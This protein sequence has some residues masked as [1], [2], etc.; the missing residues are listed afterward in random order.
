[1]AR[2]L[3]QPRVCRWRDC[4][5]KPAWGKFDDNT[6]G[7]HRL[8]HHSADVAACFEALLGDPVL[9]D[10]FA[11]AA[12][13]PGFSRLTGARLTYLAYLHDLGK[14]NVGF[15]FNVLKDCPGA[16]RKASHLEAA[17]WACRRPD[18]FEELNIRDLVSWGAG[19]VDELIRAALA[20]HGRPTRDPD[21]CK[22]RDDI[23]RP[24][25]D[26]DPLAAA[27]LLVRRGR[28]WFPEAFEDGPAI[29]S[30]PTLTHLFAGLLAVA[31]Q[32]GSNEDFFPHE[33]DPDPQYAD[34]ARRLARGALRTSGFRREGWA[35]EAH[36]ADFRTS[37]DYRSIFDFDSPRPLQEEMVRASLDSPLL[38]LEGETGSGKTE[39]ALIRFARLWR[40]GKVDGLYFAL[41]TRAAAVQIHERV[42]RALR[43][44]FPSRAE[45]GTVLAIPG[46]L[47]IGETHGQRVGRFEVEWR[48]APDEAGLQARWAAESARKFLSATA[49]VGTVDQAML[50]ALQ[51]KWAHFRCTS[52]ARSLLVVDEIH[53]SDVYMTE[54]LRGVL[55]DHLAVG[56]HALLMSA[57]LGA[58]ARRR[59]VRNAALRCGVPDVAK[60]KSTPYP[61]L[62]LAGRDGFRSIRK[63][64]D[65]GY[66]RRVRMAEDPIMASPPRIAAHVLREARRGGRV[67]VILNT[68]GQAQEVFRE[69]LGQGG[70]ARCLQLGGGPALHHSRFAAEDRRC[71]DRAVERALGK[72]RE[73]GGRIVIGT[74]TL[75]QSLDIDADVLI[76]HLCPVDVLLQRIGRLHR[77]PETER[78]EGFAEARCFVLVPEGGL[79][80]G[81]TGGLLRYGLGMSRNGGIYRDLRVLEMTRRLV[82][83]RAIWRIP[84]DNRNLVE[85]A[86]HPENSRL[87]EQELGG[88]WL[89]RST[90]VD[91][92][93]AAE[94]VAA[95]RHLLD[96]TKGF[97]GL[98]FPR[99]EHVRTRLG[100][101]GPRIKLGQPTDGPF[102]SP[103]QT[104]N[105]PAYMFRG[106]LPTRTEIES[107][108]VESVS[109]DLLLHVGDRVFRY[110]R[111]GIRHENLS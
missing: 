88:A 1:M 42:H 86:T 60:A 89:A 34:R 79:D 39:A 59:L 85:G 31:D 83:Q 43:R 44:L 74:Q 26:Y 41:P 67:L 96:R 68:V 100:E 29:P 10:R 93:A 38:I 66:A 40:A 20:H 33:P 62:T 61:A 98:G 92:R 49:A 48:D 7:F 91:G 57:T 53:A 72:S 30:M 75:E 106:G 4:K 111:S 109:D 64:E 58:T 110:N 23:W 97:R 3:S 35:D 11:N 80:A 2:T 101:D 108:H 50:A 71:L 14:L 51:V 90:D 36:A 32:L 84:R 28:E 22:G 99:D 70:G 55:R 103:V 65:A 45:F 95:K 12:G 52:L 78:P 19:P 6:G 25:G 69:V 5:P 9:R 81:L 76:T 56:G 73:P 107:A 18:V 16:P 13:E 47:R 54:I 104:F 87:L 63:I 17:I 27:R 37:E 77:H 105:L 8:E 102:G 15:Q 21:S 94:Q 82:A 24:F 46:Y